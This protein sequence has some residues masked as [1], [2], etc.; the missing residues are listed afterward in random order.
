MFV[1]VVVGSGPKL[2]RTGG[3]AKLRPK[4]EPETDAAQGQLRVLVL[5]EVPDPIQVDGAVVEGVEG[6]LA[7]H[8]FSCTLAFAYYTLFIK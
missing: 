4:L 7:L 6:T 5:S 3:P 2:V 1:V 8:A